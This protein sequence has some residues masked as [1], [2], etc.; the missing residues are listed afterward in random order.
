MKCNLKLVNY[1]DVTFN[2][3]NG[4][5]RPYRKPNDETHNICLHSDQ[6]PPI[7]KQLPRAI[8]N[9]YQ[10]CH[11]QNKYL[12]KQCHIMRGALLVTKN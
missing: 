9:G 11:R 12:K 6:P 2:L 5:Y 7:T 3:N 10:Y 4:S 1:L 8:E